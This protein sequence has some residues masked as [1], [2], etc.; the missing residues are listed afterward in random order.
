[1][2][3]R[4]LLSGIAV[5]GFVACAGAQTEQQEPVAYTMADVDAAPDTWRAV[6]P[7]NL[8]IMETSK[9]QIVLELLPVAAPVHVERFKAYV[10]SG[11]YDGTEFHRVIKGFMA[12]GGDIAATHGPDKMLGS[13]EAEFVF[14]RDPAVTPMD[15]IGPADSADGGFHLGFP[16]TTQPGFLAEMS[17]DGLVESWIPHCPGVLSSAR[18]DDA[19]SADAQFFLISDEGQHLDYK[20]TAKGRALTG[21]DVIQSIKLGP[22]QDGYPIAN[23]DV[24]VSAKIAADLP[25]A[26]RP[27]AFVQRTDTETWQTILANADG[28]RVALCDIPPVPAVVE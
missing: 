27:K 22:G 10:R 18:T 24:L 19:N 13:M 9:G 7:E 6:D 14:R 11:L 28:R 3:L 4:T 25:E 2:T 1:M 23:P 20:Y 5:M 17:K 12:Q 26:E 8:V 16:I 15:T 21:L